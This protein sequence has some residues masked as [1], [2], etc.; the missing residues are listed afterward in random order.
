MI[1]DKGK[2]KPQ[3]RK[4][5]KIF[6]GKTSIKKMTKEEAEIFIDQL[7]RL[8][9]PK[10]KQGKLIPPKVPITTKLAL[11][12]FFKRKYK[13]PTPMRYLTPQ[14]YYA[15]MLGVKPLV[16]PYEIGKQ[17]FDLEFRESSKTA[18][19]IVNKLNKIAKTPASEK[20]KSKI[21]NI[22]TKA[23]NNMAELVNKYEEPPA[24]LSQGERD[25][26]NWFR[27]LSRDL[28]NR[29]NQVRESVDLPPIKYRKAYFRHTADGM[30]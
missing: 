21:K 24:N 3:Y 7:D 30:A 2:M 6:T 29:E 17:K 20:L 11:K 22:P 1:S 27:S 28:I 8:P 18:D 15:E 4:I 12:D 10:L 19:Q 23:E 13:E 16:E 9:E 5:A 14:T 25:V 26:F